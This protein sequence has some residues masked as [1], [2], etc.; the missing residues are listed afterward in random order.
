MARAP[1]EYPNWIP[2]P[3]SSLSSKGSINSTSGS[4]LNI[5]AA[6]MGSPLPL[7]YGRCAI[8]PLVFAVK[9]ALGRLNVGMAWCAGEIEGYETLYDGSDT[10]NRTLLMYVKAHYTGDM[11][12]GV[13]PTLAGAIPGYADTLVGQVLGH[14]I[15]VAYTVFSLPVTI[16]YPANLKAIV[17]GRKVRD[18][19]QPAGTPKAYSNNAALCLADFLEDPLYGLG[20]PVDDA[21]LIDA[22]DYCDEPMADGRP[23]ATLNLAL[24]RKTS[25][26]NYIDTLRAYAHCWVVHAGDRLKLVLDRPGAAVSLALTEDLMVPQTARPEVRSS[27]DTPTVMTVEWTDASAWPWEAQK[28]TIR[29]PETLTGGLPW[30]ESTVSM[31]GLHTRSEAHRMALKRLNY[32]SLIDLDFEVVGFDETGAFEV[33]DIIRV[34][35]TW[36]LT[37]KLMRLTD[38]NAIDP[39]RYR[40]TL[41]EYDPAVY[42]DD[43]ESDPSYPDTGLP[44]VSA[45]PAVP[46]L[47]ADEEVFQTDKGFYLSRIRASWQSVETVGYVFPA[48]YQ[49][50]VIQLS[51]NELV[52][53]REGEPLQA[54]SQSVEEDETYEIRVRAYIDWGGERF[55]GPWT[56]QTLMAQGKMLPPGDVPWIR[57]VESGGNTY[58][59]WGEAHDID[60][61]RYDLRYAP[62]GSAW[63]EETANG[64]MGDNVRI[65]LLDALHTTTKD[66]PEGDWDILV[67]AI[68]SVRHESTTEARTTVTVTH[69]DELANFAR[70]DP[71]KLVSTG[72]LEWDNNGVQCAVTD[73]GTEDWDHVFPAALD[74]Y[75]NPIV[76]YSNCTSGSRVNGA[77]EFR[78]VSPIYGT[79]VAKDVQFQDLGGPPGSSATVV[80]RLQDTA[81][82]WTDYPATQPVTGEYQAAR[83]SVRGDAG[84]VIAACVPI[85]S[86]LVTSEPKRQSGNAAYDGVTAT[87][88]TLIKPLTQFTSIQVT[89]L[90]TGGLPLFAVAENPQ[91]GPPSVFE[92]TVFESTATGPVQRASQFYWEVRGI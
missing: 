35:H 85:G 20:V 8:A 23:R 60:I 90:S 17:Q 32:F 67:K 13:D 89:P 6:A 30:R 72:M 62:V 80:M 40:L 69:D 92:V 88:V 39:G 2:A 54:A 10:D 36:G 9:T 87:V 5:T 74:T 38:T 64:G 12:Q 34:T 56:S 42:T 22:A 82:T 52:Y 58:I 16:G 50:E 37:Q 57:A 26:R 25:V 86:I 27:A 76:S 1:Y 33:G 68:D 24:L 4:E 79:W 65:G 61:W 59:N 21:S 91:P 46:G 3:S 43:I 71:Q 15:G 47:S 83:I 41:E 14:P 44:D 49:V 7:V 11:A 84:R 45:L 81:G 77:P 66:L 75:A 19:R 48:L 70:Y 31:E 55:H 18:P 73:C 29:H 63:V 78:P 28:E 53:E 51:N